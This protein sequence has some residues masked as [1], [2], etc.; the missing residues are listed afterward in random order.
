MD[1]MQGGL[2]AGG[3][4]LGLGF[5]STAWGKIKSFFS[6]LWGLI[7]ITIKT[8]NWH[9]Q[10]AIRSYL[11]SEFDRPWISNRRYGMF[12]CFVKPRARNVYVSFET[13]GDVSMTFWNGWRPIFVHSKWSS[14]AENKGKDGI[15]VSFFRWTFNPDKLI[16]QATARY[17]DVL[18]EKKEEYLDTTSRFYIKYVVG[19]PISKKFTKPDQDSGRESTKKT[20]LY[21]DEVAIG[22]RRY[23]QWSAGDLGFGVPDDE[24]EL[25]H[26]V[27]EPRIQRTAQN[28]H[29]WFHSREWYNERDIPWKRGLLLKGVPGSGKTSFVRAIA[30]ELDLPIWIYDTA[31][32]TNRDFITSWRQ[33]LAATPCVALIEDID[34]VFNGRENISG[35]EGGL[36]FNCLLNAIDGVERSDGV[37]VVITTNVAKKLDPALAG[38]TKSDIASRPGRIDEVVEF[39]PMSARSRA[40]LARKIFPEASDKVLQKLVQ[41]GDGDVAAQFQ[42]RCRQAALD[43]FWE[44]GGDAG[45]HVPL[46]FHEEPAQWRDT[47]APLGA[48]S[49]LATDKPETSLQD[50]HGVRDHTYDLANMTPCIT[51]LRNLECEEEGMDGTREKDNLMELEIDNE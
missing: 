36:T 6:K 11:W 30:E 23:L 18:G 44:Q 45:D 50:E 27:L 25:E 4:L 15:T 16:D 48:P 33:M 24:S 10:R 1:A 12:R 21:D 19:D 7:F 35:V 2:L 43:Y 17:N 14:E 5:L 26:L 22:D 8:D 40:I 13:L 38:D 47:D 32:L 9:L 3:G 42:E 39:G 34:T 28:I 20:T 49:D 41:A 31:T 51:T 46:R 29:H 37:M